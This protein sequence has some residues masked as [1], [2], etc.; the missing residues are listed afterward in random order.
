MFPLTM[1]RAIPLITSSSA[2]LP[3]SPFVSLILFHPDTYFQSAVFIRPHVVFV[4]LCELTRRWP[5]L[6]VADDPSLPPLTSLL[7]FS[8]ASVAFCAPLTLTY[9][10]AHFCCLAF[11]SRSSGI[12]DCAFSFAKKKKKKKP[13]REVINAF[14]KPNLEMRNTLFARQTDEVNRMLVQTPQLPTSPSATFF[15]FFFSALSVSFVTFS[16]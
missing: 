4:T 3:K 12:C 14:P 13:P 5:A 11:E 8:E 15:V 1:S 7:H 16:K 9:P 10:F 6:A 2:A